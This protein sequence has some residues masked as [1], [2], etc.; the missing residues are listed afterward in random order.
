MSK[1]EKQNRNYVLAAF[2][3]YENALGKTKTGIEALLLKPKPCVVDDL[4]LRG[5]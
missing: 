4:S 5:A 3:I 2:L 1:S